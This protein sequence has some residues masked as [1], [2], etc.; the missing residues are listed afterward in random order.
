MWCLK[1]RTAYAAERNW[2][3]DRD[4][5]H[6]WVVAVKATFDVLPTGKLKLADEQMLPVLVPEY[7]GEPGASSLRYDSDLLAAKPGTDVL[8][9]AHAHAPGGKPAAAVPVALRVGGLDKRLLVHGERFYRRGVFGLN[10]S[11][12]RPFSSRQIR[13]EWAFGGQDFSDPD[14]RKHR[15]D[16]RNPIGRGLAVKSASLVDQP[17]H[18]LEYLQGDAAVMGPAGFGAIDRSWVPRRNLAGT[19]DERW[20]RT[21]RPLLP[22]DY[23]PAFARSA[24]MDQCLHRYL[25][26]GELIE[27]VHMTP[28]GVL[29]LRLPTIVLSFRSRFGARRREHAGQMVTVIVEPEEHRLLVVW[30]TALRVAAQEVDY[31]DET[32]IVEREGAL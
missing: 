5:A 18:C 2:T 28:E 10:L 15:M 17:A 30:Q 13:Y 6:W 9:N 19:Y 27:L 25:V 16:E 12:P 8:V 14:S 1:N 7:Y 24:P 21:K 29:R 23:D 31:L 22:E 3:R 4:G 20:A 26:G 32:E 11:P